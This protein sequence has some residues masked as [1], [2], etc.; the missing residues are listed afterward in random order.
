MV[1]IEK[2]SRAPRR[3][4]SVKCTGD[5][6]FNTRYLIITFSAR[7]VSLFFNCPVSRSTIVS[8]ATTHIGI[9]DYIPSFSRCLELRLATLQ[10]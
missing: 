1:T 3:Q 6:A 2:R 5:A 9:K 10:R 8:G 4:S 7:I